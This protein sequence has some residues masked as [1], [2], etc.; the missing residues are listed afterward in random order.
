M[1]EAFTVGDLKRALDDVPDSTWVC[2]V[3]GPMNKIRK[4]LGAN[5][6]FVALEHVASVATDKGVQT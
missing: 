1:C 6:P 5:E 4:E 3:G 2:L